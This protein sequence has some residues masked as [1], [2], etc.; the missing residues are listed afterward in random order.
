MGK[1][2]KAK[3]SS[4]AFILVLIKSH[5]CFKQIHHTIIFNFYTITMTFFGELPV[6]TCKWKGEV[7]GY[8]RNPEK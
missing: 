6:G 7:G 5:Y 4:F 1:A 3:E 8:S 2:L